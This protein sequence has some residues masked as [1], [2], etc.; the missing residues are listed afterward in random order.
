MHAVI[1]KKQIITANGLRGFGFVLLLPAGLNGQHGVC[2]GCRPLPAPIAPLCNALLLPGLPSNPETIATISSEQQCGAQQLLHIV[3]ELG[4]VIAGAMRGTGTR[5][6]HDCKQHDQAHCH[7]GL[8]IEEQC[9]LFRRDRH[10]HL[11]K[12]IGRGWTG[13]S[14]THLRGRIDGG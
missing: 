2:G 14:E 10:Q 9:K 13:L 4:A 5:T 8:E 3:R 7:S 1:D 11:S 6:R 12:L